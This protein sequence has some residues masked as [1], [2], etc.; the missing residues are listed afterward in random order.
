MFSPATA[1]STAGGSPKDYAHVLSPMSM[2]DD[3]TDL[4]P[5]NVVTCPDTSMIVSILT[6][7]HWSTVH[8]YMI[9]FLGRVWGPTN[10]RRRTYRR[11]CICQGKYLLL[12][13]VADTDFS[14][15]RC[16]PTL[17]AKLQSAATPLLMGSY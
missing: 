3:V 7:T 12:C 14:R 15:R 6:L 9:G 17:Y 2:G 5:E 1:N 10:H 11:W 8:V 16:S 13:K 4:E